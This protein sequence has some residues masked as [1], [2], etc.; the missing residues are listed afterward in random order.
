MSYCIYV[1]LAPCSIVHNHMALICVQVVYMSAIVLKI[2]ILPFCCF[3]IQ[4]TQFISC[5]SGVAMTLCIYGIFFFLL[6]I[7][8]CVETFNIC[9][10]II[11]C[12]IWSNHLPFR[13]WYVFQILQVHVKCY[14]VFIE[15][16]YILMYDILF[17]HV[18][19][20]ISC[21]CWY[22]VILMIP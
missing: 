6:L 12:N 5:I 11:L 14:T 19:V 17:T 15:F 8:Q 1:A 22:Y 21:I 20:M 10:S 13:L 4:H 7:L 3:C 16:F 9:C 18:W 2:H